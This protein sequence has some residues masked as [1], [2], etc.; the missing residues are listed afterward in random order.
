MNCE[1]NNNYN[2]KKINSNDIYPL[3]NFQINNFKKKYIK[4]IINLERIEDVDFEKCNS[5]KIE[6]LIN[7]ENYLINFDKINFNINQD[8]ETG[9]KFSDFSNFFKQRVKFYCSMKTRL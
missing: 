1:I 2:I 4:T 8:K 3:I 5:I 9:V 7:K 6:N